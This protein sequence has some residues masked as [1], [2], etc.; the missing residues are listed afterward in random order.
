[1]HEGERL[2]SLLE[3]YG[4][5]IEE[6]AGWNDPAVTDLL[7]RLGVWRAATELELEFLTRRDAAAL[8]A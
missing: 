5:A 4:V 8:A 7:V 1:M 6:L 2:A 3:M